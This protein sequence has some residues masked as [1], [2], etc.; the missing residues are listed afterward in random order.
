MVN[1]RIS[2]KDVD[3]SI[4]GKIIGGAE[5]VSVTITRGGQEAAYEGGN[6]LPVE[7]VDGKIEISGEISRAFIDVDLLN[8]LFPNQS[9]MPSFTLSGTIS[10]GKNPGRDIKV[11]GCK[12][13]S[14]NITDLNLDGYAKN[15]IPFKALNWKFA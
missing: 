10:S 4:N 13:D 7:I 14:I 15:T 2:L 8:E 5:S 3:I 1:Q 9:L 12:P 6:Y 11:F